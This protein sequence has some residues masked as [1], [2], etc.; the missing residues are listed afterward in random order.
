MK[1]TVVHF[2]CVKELDKNLVFSLSSEFNIWVML[3]IIDIL[4]IIE[5]NDPIAVFVKLLESPLN[6]L[7]SLRIHLSNDDSEEFIVADRSIMIEVKDAEQDLS[8]ILGQLDSVVLEGFEKFLGIKLPVVVVIDNL[9]NSSQT[10]DT[11]RTSLSHLISEFL[12]DLL[13]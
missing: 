9:E 7:L 2:K 8:L 13:V 3:G 6:E 11:T 1:K 4:E 12:K 5:L 10:D